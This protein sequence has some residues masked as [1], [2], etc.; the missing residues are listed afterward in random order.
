M[1]AQIDFGK[2]T[3]TDLLNY[4]VF[5]VEVSLKT[6]NKLRKLLRYYSIRDFFTLSKKIK[7]KKT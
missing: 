6:I 4:V 3:L 5:L 7:E 2:P 1:L